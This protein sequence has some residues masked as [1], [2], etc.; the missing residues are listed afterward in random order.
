[1]A[2]KVFYSFHYKPDNWRVSQVRN[3]GVIEG[4]RPAADNDWETVTKAGDGAIERWIADQMNG[5]S[6]TV[7]LI[8]R[9]TADRK[10]INHEIIKSWNDKKGI[11]G[12]FIHNLKDSNGNQVVKGNNPFDYITFENGVKLSSIVKAYNPPYYDSKQVYEYISSNLENWIDE[13]IQI[14]NKN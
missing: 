10:W 9:E 6:C 14:R 2:K 11:L 4:N 3:I 8:G 12:I 7:L 13:A 1:M 5:R